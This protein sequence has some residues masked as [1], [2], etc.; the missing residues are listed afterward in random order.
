MAHGLAAQTQGQ[1]QA[2]PSASGA[3]TNSP[4][5]LP[6]VLVR[7][8]QDSGYKPEA[9]SSPRYTEP[10]RDIPQ[11]IAVVPRAVLEAQ[12]A[13]S[14]RDVLRN[15]PG[16]SLQ[17]GEGGGGLPGDNLSIRGFN[18]RSDVFIDGIRD[19][20]AYS[21][22]PFNL[23]QV[24][25]S[26]GPTS[27]T[28]G[29]GATGGSINLVTKSPRLN[30]IYGGSFGL[31][32]ANYK[33]A[34][35]DINQPLK[36]AGL[37]SAAIRLNGLW[38]DAGVPGRNVIEE[39]RWAINP[40]VAFGLG[41]PTRVTVDFI[42]MEQENLP[43]YG[44]PWV[45]AGNTNA[46]LS[47][48]I[49][50]APPVD[51]SNFYGLEDYDYEDIR[52]DIVTAR[53]DHDF[54]ESLWLRN[55]FRYGNTYRD[56]AITAPRFVDLDPGSATV[57]DTLV[58]RQLQRRELEHEAF[59]NV[60]DLNFDF[61]TGPIQHSL[62]AG[63]EL[64]LEDQRNRNSAQATNQ[65]PTDIFRPVASAQPL[66][67]MP[68]ITGI[69]NDARAITVAPYV[70]DTLKFGEHWQLTGGFR[71]DYVDSEF[72]GGTNRLDRTDEMLSW[73]A[74]VVYKPRE[75]G[76]IYFGYGTSFTPSIAAG[77]VGLALGANDVDL[78]PEESRSFE[79]GT[80]WDL[81]NQRLSVGAAVFRTEKTNARTAGVNAGDPP[82]VL[83]GEQIVQGVEFTVAGSLTENWR[84]FGGYTFMDSE[85]KQSNTAAEVGA[86]FGNTPEHSFSLWTTYTLPWNLEVGVGAQYVGDRFNSASGNAT[87]R[88]APDYLLYDAMLGYRVN[89]NV[90]LRLNVYNL[91]DK[92]YIERVGGGHFIPGTGRFAMV[93]ASFQF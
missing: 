85:I 55:A 32:S 44:I 72:K 64:A 45:P 16:I 13:T 26:K 24:E 67:P 53:V 75:N 12:G 51:F 56:H 93:T 8:A 9:V 80:K 19:F 83:D 38:H 57:T 36:E 7:G 11:T 31:G 69:P 18:A 40:S 65:P 76:S 34:T 48:Y 43:Q 42:H 77:N 91:T 22:D 28:A 6:E 35:I 5:Q 50:K 2:Q 46:V 23:E 59:V 78:E 60:T 25:V 47:Q 37:E 10:L 90:S 15:V 27:A 84:V 3:S 87:A 92:E 49:N 61:E 14:L 79:L 29:R 66:G 52:N 1:S 82:L 58:N 30:P 41:T 54:S 74:G 71:F 63:L 17:A 89:E 81:F 4:T 39:R 68:G 73:R 70:F 20:G 21:R 86:E 62:A 88:T 33:R